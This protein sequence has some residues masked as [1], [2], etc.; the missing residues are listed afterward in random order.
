M[1]WNGLDDFLAMGGYGYYVWV[2]FGLTAVS[3]LAE[4]LLLRRR[5]Q[6]LSK[7]VES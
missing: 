2:S 6:M 4:L 1:H 5:G 3:I 7:E